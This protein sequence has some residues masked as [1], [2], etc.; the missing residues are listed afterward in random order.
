MEPATFLKGVRVLK[1]TATKSCPIFRLPVHPF[2]GAVVLVVAV[3]AATTV[4]IA[5]ASE[6]S[7]ANSNMASKSIARVWNE[8]LLD[9]IRG[10]Y[11]LPTVHARNLFHSSALMF[12]LWAAFDKNSNTFMLG[13]SV[14]KTACKFSKPDLGVESLLSEEIEDLR[15]LSISF[16]MRAFLRHRFKDA[17]NRV[18]V[19][20]AANTI[21]E[22]LGLPIDFHSLEYSAGPVR[23][24]AASLGLYAADC[25]IRLGMRDGSNER[26]A[27]KN[28]NYRPVNAPMD[29]NLPGVQ[30][31]ADAS[32]WQPIVLQKEH[33]EEKGS[34]N[35]GGKFVGAE[36]GRV[37]PFALPE[38]AAE[39][40]K[41]DGHEFLIYMDPGS[42]AFLSKDKKSID[43]YRWNHVIPLLWSAHLDPSDGV[44]WDISPA[45]LGS[46]ASRPRSINDYFDYFNI[47]EGGVSNV[48][49]KINPSTGKPYAQ[50]LV[51]RG[52]YTRVIAEYWADGPTSETPPG[53]WYKILNEMVS[54]KL[55]KKIWMGKGPEISN[56]EWDIKSY[57]LLG[58]AMHDAVVAAWSI[59]GW[60]D[61]VRPISAIRFMASRGQS[62]DRKLANYHPEGLPLWKGRIE[63]VSAGDPLA[64]SDPNALGKIKIFSWRGPDFIQNPDDDVAGTGWILAENWWPYQRPSF[65]T[66]PFAGYVSGHSTL[67]RAAAEIL[68]HIVGSPY[69]PGG[70]AE[71]TAKKNEFLV[72]ENGPST[73]VTLQW[74]TFRDAS[75]QTSL[76]RIWGGIHPPVDDIP[77][78]WLG[79]KVAVYAIQKAEKFHF[80]RPKKIRLGLK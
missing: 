33:S 10:D 59:K 29:P 56:L 21:V 70:L 48:G 52:D 7:D 41:R 18:E 63:I 58:G 61:Y 50:N 11:P 34:T 53:H 72:F 46:I 71:F 6:A 5:K 15:V 31:M 2:L 65:V 75:D 19:M 64:M 13:K 79:V 67:S 16:G 32:H 73:D 77:G 47:R 54:D 4:S 28:K 51:Y 12:D 27:Y 14:Q 39:L 35:T 30:K 20:N 37:L 74:A 8:A 60:Y 36:W 26:N 3:S 40:R 78:R 55:E 68:T 76:S 25:Y 22:K 24:R 9:A 23:Q 44:V 69:F 66:P 1:I 42:P 38:N 80:S 57:F 49:H 17:R 62:S 43:R 45:T